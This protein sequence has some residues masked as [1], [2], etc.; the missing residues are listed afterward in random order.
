MMGPTKRAY[1]NQSPTDD[2]WAMDD[3][4]DDDDD[5]ATP[6]E[7]R[8]GFLFGNHIDTTMPIDHFIQV[9]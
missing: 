8:R 4:D 5:R 1:T 2:L 9:L 3:D 6:R 7:P